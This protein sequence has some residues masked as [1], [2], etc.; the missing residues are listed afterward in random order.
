MSPLQP[1]DTLTVY[2]K[3]AFREKMTATV[4]GEV[5]KPGAYEVLPGTLVS[6]LLKLGGDLTRDAS[7]EEAELSR[8]AEDRQ[9]TILI[10]INLRQALDG[11]ASQNLVIQDRDH[12]MVRPMPDLQETRYITLK[13]EV[14]SPGMYAARKGE[15]LS[16]I[17]QRAGGFTKDAFLRGAIFTRVSVQKRQQEIIDR[18]IDQLEQDVV[19]TSAKE[20]TIAS[21]KE[22]VDSQKQALEAR[23]LLIVRLKSVRAQGR[24]ILHLSDPG[25]VAGT[26]SD[27]V[28]EPGDQLTIPPVPEVVNVL[29][30]VYNPT[31]VVF[32]PAASTTGYYL[33]KV[34]GPTADADRDHIFVVQADGSVLTKDTNQGFWMM[35]DSG[36]MSA[37]LEPGD[38]IVVPEQLV[39][40]RTMKDVKDITA[41]M[42]QLAVTLGVFLAI[43]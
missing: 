32:N 9:N 23:K 28:I 13:G 17:L 1:M 38:A 33:R 20:A 11:D 24:I 29:G 15:R 14:R 43:P 5:R 19:R 4:N 2:N 42:M 12:L 41:I 31:G 10:K 25:K 6:D 34:G 8:L 40:S 26:E 3:S 27:L 36:L 30:R 39:F 35:G 37:K 16:S 22:D 18:M 7:L 21:D